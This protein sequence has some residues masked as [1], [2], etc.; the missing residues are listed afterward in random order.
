VLTNIIGTDIYIDNPME[1]KK[2]KPKPIIRQPMKK[3]IG[4][5]H[6]ITLMITGQGTEIPFK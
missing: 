1:D 6:Q 4:F 2:F 5:N 3:P